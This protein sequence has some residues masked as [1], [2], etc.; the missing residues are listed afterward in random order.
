MPVPLLDLQAQYATISDEL[1]A[2]VLDVVRSQR[3]ILGPAVE[4]LEQEA[5]SYLGARHAIG[6]ASGRTR[7]CCR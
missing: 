5:G 7:C 6:C 1:D 4:K 3:F 2:A